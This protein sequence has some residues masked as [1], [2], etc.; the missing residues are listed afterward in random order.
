MS[1]LNTPPL[2]HTKPY[3][4]RRVGGRNRRR[5][6]EVRGCK[7]KYKEVFEEGRS[8][9]V[10]WSNGPKVQESQGPGVPRSKGPRYLKV[11]FKYELDSKEGPSCYLYNLN[12]LL[13]V[14]VCHQRSSTSSSR[15]IPFSLRVFLSFLR[16]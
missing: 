14:K 11:T 4:R 5:E 15:Y 13:P 12:Y 16:N 3:Q 8:L 9:R 6:E 7:R 1:Q 10:P 2:P